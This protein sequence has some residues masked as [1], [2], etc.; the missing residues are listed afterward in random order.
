MTEVLAAGSAAQPVLLLVLTA[1][2]AVGA[3]AGCFAGALD[4]AAGGWHL[5]YQRL[6]AGAPAQ[7]V[8][9]TYTM[10]EPGLTSTAC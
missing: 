4:S 8:M 6:T 2:S 1:A 7:G 5:L 9:H 3:A 10:L